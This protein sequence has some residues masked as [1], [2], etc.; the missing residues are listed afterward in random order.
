[1]TLAQMAQR[2]IERKLA[3]LTEIE[4]RVGKL[5]LTGFI[6]ID[7]FVALHELLALAAAPTEAPVE[8]PAEE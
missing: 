2:M 5:Y 6:T 7:E 4:E 3:P 1:M 8:V